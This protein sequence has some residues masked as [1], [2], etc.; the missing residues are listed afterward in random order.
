MKIGSGY[1]KLGGGKR[2]GT[3]VYCGTSGGYRFR[4][5]VS[6]KTNNGRGNTVALRKSKENYKLQTTNYKKITKKQKTIN[7]RGAELKVSY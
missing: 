1:W 4:S 6:E 3:R 7:K 5:V 2:P